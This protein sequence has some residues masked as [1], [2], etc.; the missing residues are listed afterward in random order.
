[1]SIFV[2]FLDSSVSLEQSVLAF[3]R[4]NQMWCEHCQLVLTLSRQMCSSPQWVWGGSSE[5]QCVAASAPFLSL[6]PAEPE[7]QTADKFM[8]I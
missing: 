4:L 2:F 7:T 6:R 1:M 8:R 5:Q 3:L